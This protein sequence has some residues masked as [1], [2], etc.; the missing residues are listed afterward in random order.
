MPYPCNPRPRILFY[1]MLFSHVFFN[2]LTAVS[3]SSWEH[4]IEQIVVWKGRVG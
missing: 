4:G 3:R 1:F 2:F